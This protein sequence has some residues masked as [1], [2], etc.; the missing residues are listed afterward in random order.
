[1]EICALNAACCRAIHYGS[2]TVRT[3]RNILENNLDAQAL[4]K[5]TIRTL[6]QHENV[7]GAGYYSTEPEV[8]PRD[9]NDLASE[10]A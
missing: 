9:D 3:I 2:Y 8:H 1:M 5:P 7:R 4:E 6:G 10:V